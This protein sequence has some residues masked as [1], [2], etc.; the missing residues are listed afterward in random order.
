VLEDFTWAPSGRLVALA[1]TSVS[2]V[3]G[4]EGIHVIELATGRDRRIEKRVEF[5]AGLAWSRDGSKIAYVAGDKISGARELRVISADG[6]SYAKRVKIFSGSVPSSPTWSPDGRRIAYAAWHGR[7][8]N[9]YIANL[10]HP[11]QFGGLPGVGAAPAWSPD[12][13]RIAI[14]GCGGVRLFTPEGRDVTPLAGA[15]FLRVFPRPSSCHSIGVLGRPAWSPD[16]TKLA[17]TTPSGGMF[18]VPASGGPTRRLSR[19][20]VAGA[21][22]VWRPRVG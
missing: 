6:S 12:G 20:N 14:R 17:I 13:S 4:Y 8:S 15:H 19:E 16:G 22:L 10:A 9:V 11:R 5:V 3:T 21:R 2:T 1:V 18:V 7:H